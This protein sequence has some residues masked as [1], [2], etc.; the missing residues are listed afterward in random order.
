MSKMYLVFAITADVMLG[1]F[2]RVYR[3][4]SSFNRISQH[5]VGVASG[6][7]NYK[8]TYFKFEGNLNFSSNLSTLIA[9]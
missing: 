2:L 5:C 3:S 6:I 7:A 1:C 9:E 8:N 4:P